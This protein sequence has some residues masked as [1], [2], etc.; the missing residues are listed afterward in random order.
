M[1]KYT[2]W[3]PSSLFLLN[4]FRNS[5]FF[6]K[7]SECK[8]CISRKLNCWNIF[9]YK[10]IVQTIL[11]FSLLSYTFWYDHKL[12]NKRFVLRFLT[13]VTSGCNKT[14]T[15]EEMK[16]KQPKNIHRTLQIVFKSKIFFWNREEKIKINQWTNNSNNNNDVALPPPEFVLLWITSCEYDWLIDFNGISTR[17]VLFYTLRFGNS[18]HILIFCVV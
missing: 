11:F 5:I 9:R 15:Q 18:V 2:L 14:E 8:S 10:F 13:I 7:N 6:L 16:V 12:R 4:K 3:P 17:L 1:L